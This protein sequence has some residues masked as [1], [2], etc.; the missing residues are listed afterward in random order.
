MF[1]PPFRLPI[2]KADDDDPGVSVTTT[3]V[4]DA[5][6]I[7]GIGYYLLAAEGQPLRW[8]EGAIAVTATTGSFLAAGDQT[9]VRITAAAT[10]LRLIRSGT[11][12]ADGVAVVNPAV[13]VEISSEDPRTQ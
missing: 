1:F 6:T 8:K 4:E 7:L 11:A 10:P 3:A 13:F 12:T 2:P 5:T 9:L